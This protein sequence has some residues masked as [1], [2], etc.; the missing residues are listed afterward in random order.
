MSW[1]TGYDL[2]GLLKRLA[3][4]KK[5]PVFADGA[6]SLK[7]LDE[8]DI[9]VG[10]YEEVCGKSGGSLG[11]AHGNKGIRLVGIFSFRGRAAEVETEL[12][13]GTYC[14]SVD[15]TEVTVKDGKLLCQGEPVILEC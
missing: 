15:E 4:V 10:T 7:A 8:Q 2:T 9:L 3:A 11:E 12:P 6:Y 1:D 14:N 5:N 13:D